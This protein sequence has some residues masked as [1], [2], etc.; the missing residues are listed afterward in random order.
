MA[1]GAHNGN[2]ATVLQL[3]KRLTAR[4]VVAPVAGV[5][6]RHF[7]G[8]DDIAPWLRL[9]EAAFARLSV[10]VR[11]WTE[12]DFR[13]ELLEKPWWSSGRMWLAGTTTPAGTS[14]L[15]GSITWADRATAAE[16]RPAV[17][18]LAVHPGWRRRGIGRLLMSALEAS[19]WDAGYRRVWLE[20]HSAWQAASGFYRRLGYETV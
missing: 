1:P 8:P 5:T 13:S 20:T 16:T 11:Q 14:A 17:H 9:R 6:L 2:M 12:E 15:V 18:W 7:E 10:G 3:S 19:C 4:P